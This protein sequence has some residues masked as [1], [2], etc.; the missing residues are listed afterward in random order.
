MP[1]I[2]LTDWLSMLG[3]FAVVIGLL[4]ATLVLLFKM[5]PKASSAGSGSIDIVSV[6]NLGGRQKLLLVAIEG[7]QVLIGLSP[8]NI[9]RLGGWPIA[10]DPDNDEGASKRT[11]DSPSPGGKAMFKQIFAD[12]L[13]KG[14]S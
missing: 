14:K 9:T 2:T 13:T 8:Q 11:E 10:Q 4:L 6:Q 1:L 3:S 5:G 12:E 7:E